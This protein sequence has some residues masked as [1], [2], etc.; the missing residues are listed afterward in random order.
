MIVHDELQGSMNLVF[1]QSVTLATKIMF[2]SARPKD[3]FHSCLGRVTVYTSDRT[4]S[5]K[6]SKDTTLK[7]N[8]AISIGTQ[9]G[10]GLHVPSI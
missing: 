4:R 6:I 9:P 1:Q 5:R 3:E 2:D 8:Q 10:E 7:K